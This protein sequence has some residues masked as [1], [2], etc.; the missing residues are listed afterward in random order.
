MVIAVLFAFAS[1][2]LTHLGTHSTVVDSELRT[3]AHQCRCHP[4]KLRAIAIQTNALGHRRAIRF[5]QATIGAIFT[6][7]GAADAR[8]DT[9]GKVLALHD[10]IRLLGAYLL[11]TAC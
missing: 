10:R 7:L 3:T 11:D 6:G 8:R 1:A 5:A 9:L 2:S 4:T